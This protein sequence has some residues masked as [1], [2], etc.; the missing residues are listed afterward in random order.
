VTDTLIG[1]TPQQNASVSVYLP[2]NFISQGTGFRFS[3]NYTDAATG[4]LL[5]PRL[6][7]ATR[8]A[9]VQLLMSYT[10]EAFGTDVRPWTLNGTGLITGTAMYVVPGGQNVPGFLRTFLFRGE[11]TYDMQTKS[12][13]DVNFEASKS[14]FQVLQFSLQVDR[15]IPARSTFFEAGL[16]MDLD[17][18][19]ESSVFDESAGDFTSRHSLYGS[20]AFDQ[21]NGMML[22][23]NRDETDKGGV[24][25]VMFVD[26]NN[27]SVYDSGDELI[28]AKGVKVGGMGRIVVG[29]D[30]VVHVSELQ[31]YFRYN[32]EVNKQQIDPNLVPLIDKFSF[33]VDP[34]QFK[35]IA[36][37]FY[38]GGTISGTAYLEE[39]GER[40]PLSGARV[41]MRTR[42]GKPV[43]TLRTF[44]DG[45]FYKMDVAPDSYMLSVD[46]MQLKFLQAAQE[47]GPL[48][49]TV[50]RYRDAD[51]ID[52]LEIDVVKLAP[53]TEAQ[54]EKPT[55]A[56][57]QLN[58]KKEAEK[59][60]A[61]VVKPQKEP[62]AQLESADSLSKGFM[63]QYQA[64][65]VKFNSRNYDD[66][67]NILSRML[68]EKIPDNIVDHCH[69][70]IGESNYELEQYSEALR[71]FSEVLTFTNSIKR[72][73]AELMVGFSHLRMGERQQAKEAFKKVVKEFPCSEDARRAQ[74][75]LK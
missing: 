57:L 27:D 70:W 17:F 4:K 35:R 20:V 67:I 63:E 22:L 42:D 65:L 31:D 59:Q 10:E 52:T 53:K 21:N 24:D 36:I 23:S 6:D 15:N 16:I 33:V 66:A 14:F 49:V 3:E 12:M 38:R 47:G 11:A 44:A 50:H 13:E 18:T 73:D 29:S 32:L 9:S 45:G 74:L 51:V 56:A 39:N 40:S 55:E 41:I 71:E 28:A 8:L 30:S 69:F 62:K 2:L 46:S 54:V 43:D 26:D 1:A 5:S 34:N 37:P 72:A 58:E 25:V 75:E 7:L 19:R 64:A 60:P 48:E 68:T 61:A